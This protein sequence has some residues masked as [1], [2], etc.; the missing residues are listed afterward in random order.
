MDNI[1]IGNIVARK[2]YGS[3]ILFKVIEIKD[4][5][6][7]L[8]GI[9]YRIEVDAPL[10]DIILQSN[11][12]VKDYREKINRTVD[13]KIKIAY[14]TALEETTKKKI[15]EILCLNQLIFINL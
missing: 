3:D 7:I 4:D 6:V 9:C 5:I 2:S 8:R 13:K 1:K 10:S 12:Y 14:R 15:L 11:T